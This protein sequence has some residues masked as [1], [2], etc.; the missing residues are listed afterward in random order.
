MDIH[1]KM[2]GKIKWAL[3]GVRYKWDREG[4]QRG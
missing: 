2:Y 4:K 1:F 3:S